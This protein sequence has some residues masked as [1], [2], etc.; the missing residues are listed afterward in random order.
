MALIF[1][2]DGNYVNFN[3]GGNLWRLHKDSNC[4][5][6]HWDETGDLFF[7]VYDSEFT[8]KS[9]N[10]GDVIIDSV[11]LSTA[12]G[13]KTAIEAVFPG[14]AGG[15]GGVA[16]ESYDNTAMS[17]PVMAYVY[18]DES[19]N[20]YRVYE[21]IRNNDVSRKSFAYVDSIDKVPFD[22]VDWFNNR[23]DDVKI[24]DLGSGSAF[25][26]NNLRDMIIDVNTF[27]GLA[28]TNVYWSGNYGVFSEGD[29]EI[30]VA[31]NSVIIKDS[32]I[33]GAG[34]CFINIGA[35]T[36][37]TGV[38]ILND[39]NKIFFNSK[40]GI[41]FEKGIMWENASNIRF[42]FNDAVFYDFSIGGASTI[43]IGADSDQYGFQI[44]DFC[45]LGSGAAGT[46]LKMNNVKMGN[47]SSL[48]PSSGGVDTLSFVEVGMNITNNATS[49][50]LTNKVYKNIDGTGYVLGVS[51]GNVTATA[52]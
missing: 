51:A 5:S 34:N 48:Q 30:S 33:H 27:T 15:G 28:L 20:I 44:G 42:H 39:R 31:G 35:N 41:Y 40:T 14:L 50:N 13:F 12:S 36:Q 1:Q 18:R 22:S 26:G 2:S 9:A 19:N 45:V 4:I 37:V 21:P 3:G 38:T 23:I 16:L 29:V 49:G 47:G 11:P 32:L 43:H 25:Q 46:Y 8:V 17:A 10:I 6:W 7:D 24:V 52:I